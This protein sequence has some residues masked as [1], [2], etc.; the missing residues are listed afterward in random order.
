MLNKKKRHAQR[1]TREYLDPE[2][3]AFPLAALLNKQNIE[4]NELRYN[5]NFALFGISLSSG[6]F[7]QFSSIPEVNI[8]QK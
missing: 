5:E 3:K 7:I 4:K 1:L 8:L 2:Q 6:Y